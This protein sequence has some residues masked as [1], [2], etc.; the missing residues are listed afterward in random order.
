MASSFWPGFMGSSKSGLI[1]PGIPRMASWLFLWLAFPLKSFAT[2]EFVALR[3][4]RFSGFQ[5]SGFRLSGF[6][7]SESL[8]SAMIGCRL[9]NVLASSC[10][11]VTSKFGGKRIPFKRWMTPFPVDMSDTVTTGPS[12]MVS[13][14][15]GRSGGRNGEEMSKKLKK[16]RREYARKM[17]EK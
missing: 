9:K 2:G 16:K 12:L 5:F 10:L 3:L 4:N 8:P 17:K 13:L 7:F 1:W 15:S 6:R 11:K 14:P